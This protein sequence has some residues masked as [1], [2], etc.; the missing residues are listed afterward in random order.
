MAPDESDGDPLDDP[1]AELQLVLQEL[2][3]AR[4]EADEI[5]GEIGDPAT[6]PG[7]WA[8][9]ANLITSLELQQTLIETLEGRAAALRQRL[10]QTPESP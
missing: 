5:R 9:R 10:G 6:E 8:A 1:A 7:D 2:T 3:E 4:A